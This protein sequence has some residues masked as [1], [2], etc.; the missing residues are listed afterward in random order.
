MN[1][2]H[3]NIRVSGK[4]QGVFFRASTQGEARRLGINGFVRNEFDGS[5][6]IEAEGLES[7]LDKFIQWCRL[8]PPHATVKNLQVMD[9][10]MEDFEEFRVRY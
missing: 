8:G 2:K 4:V 5:V 10:D 9:G 6:C 7:Q 1:K 3:L